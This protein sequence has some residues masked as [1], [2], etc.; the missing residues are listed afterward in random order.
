[1]FNVDQKDSP[2]NG[3]ELDGLGKEPQE[4]EEKKQ[5][6]G[7]FW[8]GVVAF[9]FCGLYLFGAA[10]GLSCV[11]HG[12]SISALQVDV[13]CMLEFR[14][15]KSFQRRQDLR[16]FLQCLAP[17]LGKRVAGVGCGVQII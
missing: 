13:D 3:S 6:G 1:M 14:E 7:W 5:V 11:V 2:M 9:R 17:Y 12:W 16:V 4:S 15:K 10:V 8:V